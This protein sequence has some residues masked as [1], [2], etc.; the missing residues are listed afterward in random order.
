MGEKVGGIAVHIG[1]RVAACAEAGTV[2]VSRTVKDLVAGSGLQFES[3]G[4]HELKGVAG[5][6]DLFRAS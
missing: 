5:D 4:S 6:W 1:A 3:M 2:Y